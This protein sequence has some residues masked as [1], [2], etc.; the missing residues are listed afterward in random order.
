LFGVGYV[1]GYVR[2]VSMRGKGSARKLETA[3]ESL[4]GHDRGA[5]S[6]ATSW[7]KGASHARIGPKCGVGVM[8]CMEVSAGKSM[9]T[10]A[11][12]RNGGERRVSRAAAGIRW[13]VQDNRVDQR[14]SWG[15]FL[16]RLT[17]LMILRCFMRME[18]RG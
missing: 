6:M 13:R 4:F 10:R 3:W 15:T 11:A 1:Q 17:C 5:R 16:S 8:R 18:R 14:A 7:T 2:G 12:V 9:S